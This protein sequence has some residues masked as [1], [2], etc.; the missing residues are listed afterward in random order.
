MSEPPKPESRSVESNQS[1]GSSVENIIKDLDH[2]S[3]ESLV[4]TSNVESQISGYDKKEKAPKRERSLSKLCGWCRTKPGDTD[5]VP[6][7]DDVVPPK[8]E[9][10]LTQAPKCDDE[11]SLESVPFVSIT[12]PH[13]SMR[14]PP[15][16]KSRSV[17]SNQSLGSSVEK[18]IQDLDHVSKDSVVLTS[19]VESQISGHDKKEKAPKRER[20]LNKL[21][22]WC[23]KKPRDTNTVPVPDDVVPPKREQRLTQAP[24][25][26]DEESLESVPFFSITSPQVSMS[27]PPKPESRSVESN[28]SLGSSVEKIIQDVDHVSNDS[29]VR[30]SNVE[31]QISGHDKMEKTPKRERRLNKLFGWCRK[32][33]RDTN[34]V[35]S[36]KDI[37]PP[38]NE[39]S[40]SLTQMLQE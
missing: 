37:V 33:P 19:N 4:R 27:E 32:K 35:D 38:K 8:K 24:K 14:E 34:S 5:T 26:N 31:S 1:L 16:P 25:C 17:E 36:S 2:V 23:R 21:F 10:L 9:Q 11:E 3:K 30:T 13:V 22:G 15:K 7:P 40:N 12:S 20:R 18:I 6:V 39:R 29:V 28:Q